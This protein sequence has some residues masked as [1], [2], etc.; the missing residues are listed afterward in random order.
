MAYQE[1]Y[2]YDYQ[3]Y[4]PVYD[5]RAPTGVWYVDQLLQ[6]GFRKGE[7]YLVAGEAGQGKTI[8]SLQFLKTGAEL[9]DE[10]GLYITIDEPSEDVKRGVRES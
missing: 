2:S 5:N 9:Y 7:I 8:F 3:D 1:Q 4:Y 6:G 10:P